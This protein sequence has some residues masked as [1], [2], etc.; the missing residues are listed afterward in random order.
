MELVTFSQATPTSMQHI[1]FAAGPFHVLLISAGDVAGDDPDN[2]SQP[3][4]HLFCLP[5]RENQLVAA[6][7]LRTRN[8]TF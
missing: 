6:V 3:L 5:G 2:C 8:K 4:W 1:G 7:R